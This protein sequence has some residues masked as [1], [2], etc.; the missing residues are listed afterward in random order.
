M[1]LSFILLSVFRFLVN[2]MRQ[3]FCLRILEHMNT[4]SIA[5]MN[6]ASIARLQHACIWSQ[7]F[8]VASK[9]SHISLQIAI[10]QPTKGSSFSFKTSQAF[11]PFANLNKTDYGR[12]PDIRIIDACQVPYICTSEK[13]WSRE[14]M[15]QPYSKLFPQYYRLQKYSESK[16]PNNYVE[17]RM[18]NQV[19]LLRSASSQPEIP[20][21]GQNK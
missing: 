10:A 8:V 6:T 12:R 13:K 3:N 5:H 14:S 9:N 7:S 15:L 1:I 4:A 11:K 16:Q 18:E 20:N 17:H 19:A 2:E 21:L